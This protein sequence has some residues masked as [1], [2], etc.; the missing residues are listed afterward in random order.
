VHRDSLQ[1]VPP[2]RYSLATI[3]THYSSNNSMTTIYVHH[4][5]SVSA[6]IGVEIIALTSAN[7]SGPP[8]RPP[9]A[10]HKIPKKMNF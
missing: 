1:A 8:T 5:S 7:D 4:S 3:Y 6:E 10:L 9:L 2:I